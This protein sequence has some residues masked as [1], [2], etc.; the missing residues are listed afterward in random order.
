MTVYERRP[1][2]GARFN[3]DF[4]G[5]ENWT[6]GVDVLAELAGLGIEHNFA[7]TPILRGQVFN[8]RQSPLEVVAPEPLVYL[9]RRGPKAGSLDQ[10]LLEQATALG[11]RVR[12]GESRPAHSVDIVATGPRRVRALVMGTTFESGLGDGAYAIVDDHLAPKGYAYLLVAGGKATLTSVLFREFKGAKTYFGNAVDAFVRLTG[13]RI[14]PPYRWSGFGSFGPPRSA[15]VNGRLLV[16]EA[17]G[18]QDSL[19]GFGIRWALLSGA[20]AA[21]SLLE[22]QDYDALWQARIGP[23]LQASAVNRC[24]YKKLGRVAYYLLWWALGTTRRPDI[25]MRWLYGWGRLPGVRAVMRPQ[26]Q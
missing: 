26:S 20:L 10:G 1:A 8:P 9:V 23:Y 7:A 22:E 17:A 24:F 12:L 13:Q 5:L 3:D 25:L 2:V 19:F 15:K 16:G 18:F 14:E 21:R 6:G 4:Q 11:V